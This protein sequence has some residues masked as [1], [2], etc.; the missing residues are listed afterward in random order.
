MS[1]NRIPSVGKSL[2]SRI[3]PFSSAISIARY[4]TGRMPRRAS[5]PECPKGGTAVTPQGRYVSGTGRSTVRHSTTQLPD[6]HRRMGYS[7]PHGTLL[8]CRK[9]RGI[10]EEA[11]DVAPGAGT[12]PVGTRP[13]GV[14]PRVASRQRVHRAEPE[15]S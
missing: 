11:Q 13:G 9:S 7:T 10:L 1:L 12:A 6:L 15:Q 3:F 5:A 2:M 4:L 14:R 8:A